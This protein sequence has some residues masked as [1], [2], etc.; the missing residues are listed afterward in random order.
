MKNV[1]E[2]LDTYN[3]EGTY[4]DEMG[5]YFGVKGMLYAMGSTKAELVLYFYSKKQEHLKLFC[6]MTKDNYPLKHFMLDISEF[7]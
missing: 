1:S 5:K 3:Y 6:V 2:L 7:K 4:E